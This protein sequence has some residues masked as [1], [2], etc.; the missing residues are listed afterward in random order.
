MQLLV[1]LVVTSV[2]VT[3]C[4]AR[5]HWWRLDGFDILGNS[6]IDYIEPHTYIRR[7]EN[8]VNLVHSCYEYFTNSSTHKVSGSFCYPS[9]IIT[10]VRKCS[11]S[12]M[13]AFLSSY[14]RTLHLRTKENCPITRYRSIVEYFATLP[15]NIEAG[16]ILI[17]G[18]VDIR[19]NLQV[20]ERLSYCSLFN[21]RAL[22]IF[23]H[24]T[25]AHAFAKSEYIFCGKPMLSYQ[26]YFRSSIFLLNSC[27]RETTVTGYGL[28]IITGANRA[29]KTTAYP[30]HDGHIR[31]TTI[32]LLT[33]SIKLFQTLSMD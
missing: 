33:A 9:I 32:A 26:K 22:L 17:D 6:T 25:D 15:S 16:Y 12:A 24:L 30:V 31:A 2:A 20:A 18:C 27:S 7:I 19:E 8:D 14:P 21:A 10:G 5:N 1:W 13:Y 3:T 29:L 28:H 4:V 23:P 11:T